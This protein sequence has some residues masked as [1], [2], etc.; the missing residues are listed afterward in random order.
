MNANASILRL[1]KNKK[2]ATM[3]E[4][5]FVAPVFFTILLGLTDFGY[6]MYMKSI[7]EGTV[8]QAAR[9]ATVGDKTPTQIDDFVK[10]QLT[11]FSTNGTVTITKTNYYE[12]SDIGKPE[13][14]T[15]D[16]NSNGSW[17][18][19]DCYEDLNNDSKWNA[20]SGRSGLGGS[21]D[22]VY[23]KVDF[24][25]PRIVPMGGFLGWSST[26]TASTMT[27]MRNQPYAAQQ[28]PMVKCTST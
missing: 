2:G 22:I 9:L 11:L 12:F 13:K 3:V 19:G 10:K 15:T 4:F 8:Y 25:Y 26:E 1:L 7:V 17:D 18:T 6:R 14:L 5:A 16:L 27:I 23:Y 28:I 24:S 20:V 21:D